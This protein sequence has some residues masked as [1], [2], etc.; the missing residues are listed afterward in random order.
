VDESAPV[1]VSAGDIEEPASV[2]VNGETGESKCT[3]GSAGGKLEGEDT[4]GGE[5]TL[6][7]GGK[8]KERGAGVEIME[9]SVG[10]D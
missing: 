1:S 5:E 8:N 6:T 2:S 3:I 10:E 9:G 4:R 7:R